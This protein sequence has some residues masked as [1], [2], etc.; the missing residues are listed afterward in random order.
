MKLPA[1]KSASLNVAKN[2]DY[3]RYIHQS[4]TKNL[5]VLKNFKIEPAKLETMTNSDVSD[6]TYKNIV[7]GC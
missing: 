5:K 4:A 1:G 2:L 3:F 6:I 7:T